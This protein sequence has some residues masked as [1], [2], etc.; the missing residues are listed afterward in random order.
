TQA[1]Q[2]VTRAGMTI[3][4]L[5]SASYDDD[6]LLDSRHDGLTLEAAEKASPELLARNPRTAALLCRGVSAVTVRGFTLRAEAERVPL[7][8]VQN[9][10][11]GLLFEDLDMAPGPASTSG[12][13]IHGVEVAAE[14]TPIV[15]QHC[16]FR[17]LR[18][19]LVVNGL[20]PDY[21]TFVAAGG[22]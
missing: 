18:Y 19:A 22:I 11:P 14:Q 13:E 2:K 5:D 8:H 3:Q 4:V 6:I 7:V 9:S 12:I 21:R 17:G 15:I 20:A 16:R 10:C 1:L